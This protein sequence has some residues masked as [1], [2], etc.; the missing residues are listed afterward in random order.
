MD[1][2][3]PDGRVTSGRGSTDWLARLN[4]QEWNGD[5]TPEELRTELARRAYVWSGAI[6]RPSL[7]DD[8]FVQAL[9]DA[10]LFRL[11][12]TPTTNNEED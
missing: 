4:R 6:V 5:L 7:P 1:A 2:H 3:W 9:A 12:T 8:E 11:E 10:G